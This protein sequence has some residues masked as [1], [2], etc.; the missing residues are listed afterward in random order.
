[1]MRKALFIL[2][3][4]LAP[5]AIQG[6]YIENKIDFGI[7]TGAS[8]PINST[9]LSRDDNFI[10]PSLFGNYGYGAGVNAWADYHFSES[11]RF[12]VAL[13]FTRY[14]SWTGD[15]EIFI[16]TK[17]SLSVVSLTADVCYLP[18]KLQLAASTI[19][20]GCFIAPVLA[21]QSLEW[22]LIEQDYSNQLPNSSSA[23]NP[24][25]RTGISLFAEVNNSNGL[26]FDIYYQF[27][28]T[29]SVYY[30]D[31][32]FHS[33]NVTVGIFFKV[34]KNRFFMYD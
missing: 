6:Q 18:K 19:K 34:L 31:Q 22:E 5:F 26:R 15:Q 24:G 7:G 14:P 20:W 28:N 29:E 12:G 30:L 25:F 23:V 32:T 17:P 21:Y 10:Y 9:E 33:V 4:A 13:G 8:I 3:I 1:M 27:L 2:L 11:I 16:L